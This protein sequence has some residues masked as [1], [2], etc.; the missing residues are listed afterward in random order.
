MDIPP[1]VYI[2]GSLRPGSVFYFTDEELS[3][4]EPHYFIVL[5][6]NPLKDR[7]LLLVCSQSSQCAT[8]IRRKHDFPGTVVDISPA[9]YTRFT[10]DSVVDCNNPFLRTIAELGKKRADGVLELRPE[11]PVDIV[12]K[13]RTAAITSDLVAEELKD[14]IR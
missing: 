3:S 9:E 7:T 8:L 6:I 11:M 12:Q 2:R 1:E 4:F 14:M 5:N 13:L 10:R